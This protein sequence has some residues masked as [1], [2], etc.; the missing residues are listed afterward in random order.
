M[1][2]NLMAA[3]PKAAKEGQFIPKD[4]KSKIIIHTKML[5]PETAETLRFKAPTKPGTYPFMC[6]FPGHWIIMKGEMIVK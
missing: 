1:A 6:T 4:K 3:D 5:A 2:A